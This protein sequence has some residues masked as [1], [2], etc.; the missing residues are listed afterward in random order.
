MADPQ[1][2]T[3]FSSADFTPPP[4]GTPM[5][6][7]RWQD[8]F[9]K[10]YDTLLSNGGSFPKI[11]MQGKRKSYTISTEQLDQDDVVTINCG[12]YSNWVTNSGNISYGFASNVRRSYGDNIVVG[13]QFSGYSNA[14]VNRAIIFGGNFA[15]I[16]ELGSA[17]SLVGL[18][19]NAATKDPNSKS[20]KF[21]I[22]FVTATYSAFGGL[23]NNLYNY[24]CYAM[25]IDSNPRSATNEFCGWNIALL[26]QP[27]GLDVSSALVWNA[28]DT[29]TAGDIVSNA[30]V[31]WLAQ[32]TST[33][34][35]PPF[36]PGSWVQ[37]SVTPGYGTTNYA[38]GI[39][40]S[41]L[42]ALAL[43]RIWSAIR[44]TSL[45]PI[46]WDSAGSVGSFYDG[47]NNR[48]VVV[49][50]MG[51]GIPVRLMEVETNTGTWRYGG[52]LTAPGPGAAAALNT[53]GA[54]G[55]TVALQASWWL[56]K[57]VGGNPFFVPVWR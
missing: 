33:N 47:P 22:T 55:P 28:V 41:M 7:P 5:S 39:D 40:F 27:N 25:S 30:G 17:S 38:V 20:S 14:G 12:F 16:G 49:S 50:N 51:G 32:G 31:L 1:L 15:A 23:G 21:G 19:I 4:Q 9:G 42:N 48:M 54:A 45:L 35:I 37:R 34:A 26:F 46:H 18:E 3:G 8:W 2:Q 53:I 6:D 56:I 57:D 29:Y 24:R 13:G 11:T 44:L 52:G 43:S 10:V 36:S